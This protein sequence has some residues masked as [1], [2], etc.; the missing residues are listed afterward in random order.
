MTIIP[1]ILSNRLRLP[2]FPTMAR[3]GGSILASVAARRVSGRL[4]ILLFGFISFAPSLGLKTI[5]SVMVSFRL[6]IIYFAFSYSYD[7]HC[8]GVKRESRR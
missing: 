7:F 1:C 3:G 5:F 2:G 8:G 6:F 4:T